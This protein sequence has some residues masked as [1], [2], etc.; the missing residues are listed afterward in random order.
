MSARSGAK[1]KGAGSAYEVGYGRPPKAH[2]FRPGESGNPRGRPKK[3]PTLYEELMKELARP[4]QI[5]MRNRTVKISKLEAILRKLLQSC[6]EGDTRA[7][8]LLLAMLQAA[9]APAAER[10]DQSEF[11][12]ALPDE[13]AISRILRRLESRTHS[14]RR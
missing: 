6:L 7:T 14:G 10:D 13:E 12:M 5:K 3:T 1:G 8:R 9:P 2:R 4:V 11:E